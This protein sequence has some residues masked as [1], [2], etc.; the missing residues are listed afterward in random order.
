MMKKKLSIVLAILFVFSI[1]GTVFAAA[2]NPFNDVPTDHWA[3]T[4]VTKLAKAGL[5]EGN[6]DGSFGGNRPLSRYEFGIITSKVIERF[7]KAD[8]SNKDLINKLSAEFAAELNQL[9]VRVAKVEAKTKTWIGGET[10]FRY[11]ED[12]PTPAGGIKLRGADKFDWRQRINIKSDITDKISYWGRV[13]AAGKMGNMETGSGSTVVL[14][15]MSITAKDVLGLD[16]IRVG[17]SPLDTIG[18][19]LIGK[20][21][22]ADGITVKQHFG[23]VQFKAYTGNVKS[24]ATTNLGTGAANT[25]SGDAY[26]LTT[27][28]LG[29]ELADN[30][31]VQAGYYWAD[32]PGTAKGNGMGT[33]NMLGSSTGTQVFKE[34]RGLDISFDWKFGKYS[35]W[36]D[37]VMTTLDKPVGLQ[38]NPKG[39]AVQ[40]SNSVGPKAYYNAVNLVNPQNIGTDAWMASYRSIDAGAIPSGA[41]GFD[42]MANAYAAQPYSVFTHATDNVNVL[43]LAYQKVID[44]NVV[45]SLEYQD[46]KIKD[47]GLTNLTS[48]Q[49]D[50]TYK[51]QITLYY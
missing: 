40:L 14:D 51:A 34:S 42:T 17:R 20:V 10:R 5:I 2:P 35:I 19:S 22:G 50:K 31:N 24:A 26:Q 27:A 23:D 25:D 8:Q 36:A 33:V 37:Y 45:M 15:I 47:R 12:N 7:E 9:G 21:S 11:F 13:S 3:Y 1:S 49:L 38:S 4:A 41:T 44:K 29:Y 18:Y 48:K 46:F 39:W 28:Q 32:I 43:F 16:S 30:M 6:G